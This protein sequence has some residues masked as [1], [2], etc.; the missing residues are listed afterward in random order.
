M[1]G[2]VTICLELV[3]NGP[4]PTPRGGSANM[5]RRA[6]EVGGIPESG[7]WL[8]KDANVNCVLQ[9]DVLEA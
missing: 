6:R 1:N 5:V 7:G 8:M 3:S 2:Y 9:R 4:P